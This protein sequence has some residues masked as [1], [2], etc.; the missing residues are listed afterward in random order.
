MMQDEGQITN[1]RVAYQSTAVHVGRG[2]NL[3]F[4][5]QADA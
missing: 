3:L 2:V 5:A 1:V 4:P